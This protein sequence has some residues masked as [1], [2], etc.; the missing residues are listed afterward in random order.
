MKL[1]LNG[2]SPFARLVRSATIELAIE[3]ELVQVDPWADQAELLDISLLS[4]VPVLV[5]DNGRAFSESLLILDQLINCAEHA[6]DLCVDDPE[7]IRELGIAYG[8]MELA[9]AYTIHKKHCGDAGGALQTRRRTA[10][11]RSLSSSTE[12]AVSPPRSKMSAA[13]IE[14]R[15]LPLMDY[16]RMHAIFGG[17]LRHSALALQGFHRNTGLEPSIMVPAFFNVLIFSLLETSRRQIVASVTV[18]LSGS[19]SV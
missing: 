7:A 12:G 13:T 8:M 10:L 19:S 3:L 15:L 14:Q 18:R 2:T 11:R 1:Y 4:R 16:R 6:N 9:F 5:D 17:Q